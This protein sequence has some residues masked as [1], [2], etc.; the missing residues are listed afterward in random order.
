MKD[1]YLIIK[2]NP[3]LTLLLGENTQKVKNYQHNTE[4]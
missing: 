2:K 4:N 3:Y 1:F